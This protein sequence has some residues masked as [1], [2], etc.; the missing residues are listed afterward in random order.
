MYKQ[1]S[2]LLLVLLIISSGLVFSQTEEQKIKLFQISKDAAIESQIEKAKADSIAFVEGIPI[3]FTNSIGQTFELMKFDN[4]FPVYYV[5]DNSISS[6]T[7]STV[8]TYE[9]EIG[10]YNLS[11]SG[12]RLGVW[13]AGAVLHS[14]QEFG[15]RTIQRDGAVTTHSHSTHVAGTMIAGGVTPRAKGM[16]YN[17]AL[18]CYEWTSDLSEVSSAAAN[19]LRVS[20]HSYGSLAGWNFDQL[21]DGK[22]A[23]NGNVAVSTS[24]DYKFGFYDGS[25]VNWDN[26]LYNAPHLLVCKSAGNDRGD[27]PPA[28]TQH[29]VRIN[30]TWTLSSDTRQRD[31]GSQGYDCMGDG[32]T[33]AKNVLTVGAVGGITS[34]YNGTGSVSMSSFSSWGPTDDGRIKPDVVADGVNLFSTN[35]TGTTQYTSMSGTSMATPSVS[36]SVGILLQHQAALY[37]ASNPFRS[38]TMKGLIIHTADECGRMMVPIIYTAGV[39]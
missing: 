8:R 32:R 25:S 36:G 10:G 15:G 11:G 39:C 4:G 24:E 6:Q 23:W 31:G 35:N 13:D 18:D 14:H 7:V 28:G 21:N 2:R 12:Q 30:G 3:R 16:S 20:S 5:T 1:A 37:G 29:W 34:G 9:N 38:A 17:A 26:M 22:W 19:G 27:G 33:V